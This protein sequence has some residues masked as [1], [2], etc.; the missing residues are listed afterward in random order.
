MEEHNFSDF[1]EQS[2]RLQRKRPRRLSHPVERDA[3]EEVPT[4]HDIYDSDADR[5][6]NDEPA[7]GDE[8]VQPMWIHELYDSETDRDELAHDRAGR[9]E[10]VPTVPIHGDA[11]EDVPTIHDIYDSDADR[12][13]NDE[14][15]HGDEEVQP[16]WIHELYDSDSD[17]SQNH[18]RQRGPDHEEVQPMLIHELFVSDTDDDRENAMHEVEIEMVRE[19]DAEENQIELLLDA[20]QPRAFIPR[21]QAVPVDL[22]GV[23]ANRLP[24]RHCQLCGA[25]LLGDETSLLCCSNGRKV[26]SEHDR[27][28]PPEFAGLYDRHSDLLRESSREIN[29]LS[30][31][32]AVGVHTATQVQGGI[33]SGNICVGKPCSVLSINGFHAFLK[34]G[35]WMACRGCTR[36]DKKFSF[37]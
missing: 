24:S 5:S 21:R 19:L 36:C 17:R 20:H 12:S 35:F 13:P 3:D 14:P 23:H 26:L 16:M 27:Y 34:S 37:T 22:A 18:E 11:D 29:Q 25:L 15:A 4:I 8:E 10:K 7:H 1:S 33:S 9:A 28:L 30:S 2:R 6:Q 31:M 32:A